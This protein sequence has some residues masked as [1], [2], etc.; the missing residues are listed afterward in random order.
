[1]K[2]KL[3]LLMIADFIIFVFLLVDYVKNYNQYILLYVGLN[4]I[5]LCI[6]VKCYYDISIV[7]ID[8]LINISRTKK[9]RKQLS[10]EERYVEKIT[11]KTFDGSNG[12][13]HPYIMFFKNGLNGYKYYM[14]HTPYDNRNVELENPSL[15]VSNDGLNFIKPDGIK[16]PLLPIIKQHGMVL[17]YY[18]DNWLLYDNNLLQV[19]YRYTEEDKTT[20]DTKL[21]NRI[22]R[23]TS[24]DGINFTEPELMIDDDGIWYLSPSIVKIND[25]YYLYYYD[26]DL[27]FYCKCSKDLKKWSNSILIEIDRFNG[28]Y[29]HGEVK[30]LKDKLYLLFLSKDYKLYFCESTIN[31]PLNFKI[32]DELHFNYYDKCNI[33]GNVYKYKSTFLIND[34]YISFY[35]PFKVNK[36]NWFKFKKIRHVKWT[37]T[38]TYL[39]ISNYNKIIK[40]KDDND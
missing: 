2:K 7:N 24:K 33:Y 16:D 29:W 21:I 6:F 39:K 13:T 14:V 15:C 12:T 20:K 5:L 26:K 30:L 18:N 17:R 31:N 40:R 32:C 37:M 3:L 8:K 9:I 28:S 27:K 11:I 19:W 22:Y 38:N 10:N 34:D 1:M 4:I 36:I 25:I 35:I 23:I